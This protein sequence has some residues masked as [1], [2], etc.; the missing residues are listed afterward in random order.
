MD[1]ELYW[2]DGA[3]SRAR[4]NESPK[5]SEKISRHL[6]VLTIVPEMRAREVATGLPQA[7]TAHS[8]S[9]PLARRFR[10]GCASHASF[11]LGDG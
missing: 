4:S 8:S 1:A 5:S 6:P 2:N 11:Y 9:L 7:E 3:R 10:A